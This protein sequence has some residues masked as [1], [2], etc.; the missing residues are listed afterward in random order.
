MQSQEERIEIQH[1]RHRRFFLVHIALQSLSRTSLTMIECAV[2][3]NGASA[4]EPSS[5]ESS[6]TH[7]ILLHHHHDHHQN[8][9]KNNSLFA[10]LGK[11]P[12]T[13]ISPQRRGGVIYIEGCEDDEEEEQRHA[14]TL[15]DD[16]SGILHV[17]RS[18]LTSLDDHLHLHHHQ[19]DDTSSCSVY[20][21]H[22]LKYPEIRHCKSI[23]K[24]KTLEDSLRSC[25]DDDKASATHQ[26][27]LR[28]DSSCYR[29]MTR[30]IKS[31]RHK[32]R[33]ASSLSCQR[34]QRN[35]TLAA[36][37]HSREP[38]SS[39]QSE[40][41]RLLYQEQQQQQ[42]QQEQLVQQQQQEQLVQQQQ[43]QPEPVNAN[44]DTTTNNEDDDVPIEA[45]LDITTL[46]PESLS[47]DLMTKST[48][49][50]TTTPPSDHHHVS[51][52]TIQIRNYHVML[53][54]NPSVSS[55]PAI[56]LSWNFEEQPAVDVDQY[57]SMQREKRRK[58][59]SSSSS[60]ARPMEEL[61]L[62]IRERQRMLQELGV[63]AHEIKVH[64]KRMH[65]A[66]QQQKRAM[67]QARRQEHQQRTKPTKSEWN[68][69]H[70]D[71]SQRRKR[72]TQ[73][74][75]R[76]G[77]DGVVMAQHPERAPPPSSFSDSFSLTDHHSSFEHHFLWKRN[78]S[79]DELQ[80]ELWDRAQRWD[81]DHHHGASPWWNGW[82]P[83]KQ[84]QQSV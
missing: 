79:D 18:T 19:K 41:E 12:A 60:R 49:I 11:P 50:H 77:G 74:H 26:Q 58:S 22:H 6:S 78:K 35:Q 32:K 15:R 80:D 36:T 31:I 21:V 44:H 25:R 20:H 37:C 65:A 46:S 62:S 16:T 52:S 82:L 7:K 47:N 69:V 56:G 73:A 4:M 55:G 61:R 76:R 23:L 13:V 53:T 38:S 48:M 3:P 39:L 75:L 10:L 43:Q 33:R 8:S 24:V 5:I 59:G 63:P 66:R 34:N 9:P 68:L 45:L 27:Q 28:R 70:L 42:Q 1:H 29:Q 2:L 14:T 81:D 84:Q 54:D 17:L 57:E 67:I 71:L 30:K 72:P 40:Q 64:L 51:F 83:W